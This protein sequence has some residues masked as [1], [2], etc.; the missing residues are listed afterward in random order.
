[1]FWDY[2]KKVRYKF[3][4]AY[5][6]GGIPIVLIRIIKKCFEI[7]FKIN[8]AIWFE[9]D[10]SMK[11]NEVQIK[12]YLDLSVIFNSFNETVSWITQTLREAP[13]KEI[14]VAR[15]QNHYFQTLRYNGQI[16]GY[17]KVGFK[18]VYI[19]DFE[20]IIQF[21]ENVA[22]IY[23]TFISPPFRGNRLA[24]YFIK[25]LMIYL[26]NLGFKKIRCHIPLWNIASIKTYE[27]CGFRKI[28]R[29]WFLKLFGIKIF[30]FNP[31]RL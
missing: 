31:E 17:I 14:E 23:D 29:I 1:M 7:S 21:P 20:G 9:R 8:N 30:S 22:F 10:L 25:E 6:E 11:I 24:S 5:K 16:I 13:G 15:L 19:N 4:K 2:L 3:N 12:R 28:K 18:E 26:K 27:R